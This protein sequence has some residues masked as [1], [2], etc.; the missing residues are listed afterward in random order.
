VHYR[1]DGRRLIPALVKHRVFPR[2]RPARY[3]GKRWVLPYL[4][5]DE[6]HACT[7]ANGDG[8]PETLQVQMIRHLE[9]PANTDDRPDRKSGELRA[10]LMLYK[11]VLPKQ[12]N[13]MIDETSKLTPVVNAVFPGA[14][15]YPGDR[16]KGLP[17]ELEPIPVA[18]KSRNE[19]Y[20]VY[21]RP[22]Q[23]GIFLERK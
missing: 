20:C 2:D 5:V 8:L 14:I 15:V 23:M 17:I 22:W 4:W 19:R 1:W 9:E 18:G 21:F 12:L 13:G 7:D 6:T 16:H 3:K 11:G 10:H